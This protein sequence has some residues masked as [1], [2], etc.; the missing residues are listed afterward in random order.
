MPRFTF[1]DQKVGR[2]RQAPDHFPLFI[3][4]FAPRAQA[5]SATRAL[6]FGIHNSVNGHYAFVRLTDFLH[7]TDQIALKLICCFITKPP[8]D[9]SERGGFA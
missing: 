4:Q 5:A 6:I 3:V 2:R 8:S 7:A 9:V 1:F